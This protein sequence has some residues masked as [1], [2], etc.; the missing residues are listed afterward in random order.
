MADMTDN[1]PEQAEI[2][3]SPFYGAL[4]AFLSS[5]CC[6]LPLAA[7]LFGFSSLPFLLK[8]TTLRSYFIAGSLIVMAGVLWW[9]WRRNQSCCSTAEKK[10][11][12]LFYPHVHDRCLSCCLC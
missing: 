8:I 3:G 7:I 6:L 11:P 4:V 5:L 9:T 1:Q 12:P 2:K 10:T